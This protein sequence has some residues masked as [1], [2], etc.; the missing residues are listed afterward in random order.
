MCDRIQLSEESD[1]MNMKYHAGLDLTKKT[2]HIV[3]IVL[4]E[5][6]LLINNSCRKWALLILK[7]SHSFLLDLYVAGKMSFAYC[8]IENPPRMKESWWI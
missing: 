6:T 3:L 4:L 7:S 2:A 5:L 1:D 8:Q